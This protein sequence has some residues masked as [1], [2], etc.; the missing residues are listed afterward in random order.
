MPYL[1]MT[2]PE[3]EQTI[4]RPIIYDIINQVKTIT[5]IEDASVF[6]PGSARAMV[7]QGSSLN[8]ESREANLGNREIVFIEV[9][10]TFNENGIGTMAITR[11]EFPPV[12]LDQS[13]GVFIT[14]VYSQTDISINFKYRTRSKTEAIR[15][16][17]DAKMRIG[18]LRD[19]NLH[20]ITYSFGIPQPYIDLLHTIWTQ[21]EAVDGYGET[22]E[23]YLKAY[24]T[25]RLTMVGD[26]VGSHTT[27]VVAE[28]QTAV[29]GLF[30]WSG[31]PDKPERDDESMTHEVS[32]AYKFTYEKPIACAVKYPIMV[33]NQLLPKEYT[34][35]KPTNKDFHEGNKRLSISN[36]ALDFFSVTRALELRYDTTP[37]LAIPQ[38]DEFID[39]PV[40]QGTGTIMTVLTE[41]DPTDR[42]LLFNLKELGDIALDS[43]VLDFVLG[44]ET[45]YI[46]KFYKSIFQVEL[47]QKNNYRMDAIKCNYQGMLSTHTPLSLRELNR[48]RISLVTD[49]TMLDYAAIERLKR[50]PA[51]FIKIMQTINELFRD[52]PG[53]TALGKKRYLSDGDFEKIFFIMTGLTTGRP[54][55]AVADAAAKLLGMAGDYDIYKG[56]SAAPT[57][58]AMEAQRRKSGDLGVGNVTLGSNQH[59]N[60][61]GPKGLNA[62]YP[63]LG[64]VPFKLGVPANSKFDPLYL[65]R[66]EGLEAYRNNAVT[67]KTVMDTGVIALRRG[68]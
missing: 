54:R 60:S 5:G 32:F 30:G 3:T 33:H 68:E 28:T 20:D 36:Q 50:Y 34:V 6:F 62:V 19:I 11:P 26:I 12:F 40:R 52:N 23:Q 24:S 18:A 35:F 8:G 2:I 14:P 46:G 63:N 31:V 55:D 61:S 4:S 22:F 27:L 16:V 21:R 38:H 17:N 51:A 43:D 45:P 44:S 56:Y 53:I 41:L 66:G 49:L 59:D 65:V 64:S 39:Y 13:L 25:N 42:T 58:A 48:V 57:A 37:P 9:E 15:W 10:E 47:Y 29:Q 7:Q 67:T 1:S